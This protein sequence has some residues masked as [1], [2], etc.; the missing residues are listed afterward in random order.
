[1]WTKNQGVSSWQG[2]M[3]PQ[4]V[5]HF[6]SWQL[7]ST[8]DRIDVRSTLK[9][10]CQGNLLAQSLWRLTRLARSHLVKNQTKTS[11]YSQLVPLILLGFKRMQGIPYSRWQGL[12]DLQLILEPRI[13]EAVLLDSQTIEAMYNLGSERLLELR[14]HGLMHKGTGKPKSA[15]STWSLTGMH[16]TEIGVLPK[17]TQTILTQIWLAHPQSRNSDMILDL[18]NWDHMPEPLV[19]GELFQSPKTPPQPSKINRQ[20]S[21]WVP[22][23][24]ETL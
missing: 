1:M 15:Q 3:M 22:P 20:N 10:N 12:A 21:P 13:S 7:Q 5:A 4:M 24:E 18:R 19:G 6:G 2:W 8:G 11:S 23:W 17:L 16:D 14:T 9:H